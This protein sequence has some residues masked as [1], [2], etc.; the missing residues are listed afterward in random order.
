MR[1]QNKR[2]ANEL[3]VLTLNESFSLFIKLHICWNTD[4]L[5]VVITKNEAVEK[6]LKTN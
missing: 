5:I 4:D 2:Q 6:I 3:F 1:N